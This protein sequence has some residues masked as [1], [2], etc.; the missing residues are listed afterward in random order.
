MDLRNRLYGTRKLADGY[1]DLERLADDSFNRILEPTLLEDDA[2]IDRQLAY[3]ERLASLDGKW[4][5]LG[6][7]P[8]P[9]MLR[10]LRQRGRD[11]VGVEPVPDFVREART[12]LQ[13]PDRVV[14]GAAESIPLA[15]G[16]VRLVYCNSVLE[17]VDS[18]SASLREMY[19]VLEPGG[20]AVVITT[21][22][23]RVS[24][25]GD[26]GEYNLP[27][28]N[29][30]PEVVQ[31]SFVFHHLHYDPH[32]ANYTTRPAVHWFSFS[33]LCRLGREA[34]FAQFYSTLDLLAPT[35]PPLAGK[36][37]KQW[38]LA[39][40]QTNPWLRAAVLTGTYFGGIVIMLK[41]RSAP[42]AAAPALAVG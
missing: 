37:W 24:L 34:G 17:H 15:E 11:V 35:D 40:V 26:N 7:G 38:T 5:V 28:F 9:R 3:L 6:C 30:L 32:L 42:R 21:N 2:G 12:F 1:P 10:Y 27:F 4:V 14:E 41:R 13:A 22:R 8:K 25:K 39:R 36:R 18:P 16:S 20:I 29:W 19:R 23:Y 33:G 31:E